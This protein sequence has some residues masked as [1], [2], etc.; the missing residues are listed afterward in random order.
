MLLA[1]AAVRLVP[2]L[3]GAANVGVT[4]SNAVF[5]DG[6][7]DENTTIAAGDTVTWTFADAEPHTVTSDSGAFDSGQ[8]QT[9]GTYQFTF[10]S[11][12][13]YDYYCAVH[14]AAGGLGMSGTIT[15]QAAPTNTTAPST[16][17]P[18]ATNTARATN[19]VT[20]RT[21][22]VEP[23]AT[24][25]AIPQATSTQ[26]VIAGQTPPPPQSQVL[27]AE[28]HPVRAPSVGT[29]DGGS[30]G[31][32]AMGVLTIALAAL[33]AVAIACGGAVTMRR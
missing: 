15:V 2:G 11:A 17:T 21:A 28:A 33:G 13:T 1:A 29:G 25:T 10:N 19:T 6:D 23:S 30:N 18:Q 12:G 5:E 3:V 31:G 8:P 20:T 26:V 4:G 32:S 14:G 27:A 22:T 7:G 9:G 16:N 24:G